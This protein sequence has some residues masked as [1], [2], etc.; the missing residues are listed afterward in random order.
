MV[1]HKMPLP[2]PASVHIRTFHMGCHHGRARI[3]LVTPEPLAV[4]F[5]REHADKAVIIGLDHHKGVRMQRC[6]DAVVGVF[7]HDKLDILL[8]FCDLLY[9]VGCHWDGCRLQL[10]SHAA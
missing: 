5:L 6:T 2:L 3:E 9:Q 8:A 10:H 4:F 7:L 1:T